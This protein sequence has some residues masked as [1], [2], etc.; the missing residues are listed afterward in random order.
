[1]LFG[2]TEI[3]LLVDQSE[4]PVPAFDTTRLHAQKAVALALGEDD[5]VPRRRQVSG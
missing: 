3:E 4:S 2:C 1:V 5:V